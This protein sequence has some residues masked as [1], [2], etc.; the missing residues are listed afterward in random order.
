[1]EINIQVIFKK[2]LKMV[3]ENI[4]IQTENI[5]LE[6]TK[7][8]KRKD[9]EVFIQNQEQN[10]KVNLKKVLL[11]DK[12][13]IFIQMELNMKESLNKEKFMDMVLLHILMD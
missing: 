4:I 13:F 9:Q 7:T 12:V 5:T 10:M 6:N 11:M 2:E 8:I 1:M 3:K